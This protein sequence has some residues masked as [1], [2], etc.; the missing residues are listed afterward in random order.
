M[1]KALWI[2]RQNNFFLPALSTITKLKPTGI[3]A[4]S[5]SEESQVGNAGKQECEA[6]VAT[7]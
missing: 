6:E 1:Q 2:L 4:K 7:F 3:S 5:F